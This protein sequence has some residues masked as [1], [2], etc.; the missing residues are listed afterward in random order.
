MKVKFLAEGVDRAS[1]DLLPWVI[2]VMVYL[3]GLALAG[4]LALH[5]SVERWTGDM[6]HRLTVQVAAGDP[7]ERDRQAEAAIGLLRQAPGVVAVERVS[8]RGIRDLLEPWLGAGNVGPDLPVPALIDVQLDARTQMGAD[9]LA[10]RLK[11]A[12]PDATV[13][14]HEQWLGRLHDLAFMVQVTAVAIVVLVTLATIAIVIFGTHAGLA[15]HRDTI[16]TL[17]IMGADDR[18]IARAFQDRFLRL[19]VKGGLFGLAVAAI[20]IFALRHMVSQ[21]GEGILTPSAVSAG[22]FAVLALLPVAAGV[23]AMMT[24]RLTVT[25]ALGRMV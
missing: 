21:M 5:G 8:E 11:A 22:Q 6:T 17:H 19:G 25:R 4:A 12:A 18:L 16:E 13:D 10:A 23:I 3:S 9:A 2:A 15:A 20:S 24:A 7:A 1:G 14:D